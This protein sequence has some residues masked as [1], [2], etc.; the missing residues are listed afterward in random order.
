MDRHA[1][2]YIFSTFFHTKLSTSGFLGVQNWRRPRQLFEKR[3]PLFPKTTGA[4]VQCLQLTEQFVCMTHW[5]KPAEA[6]GLWR[7]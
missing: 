3:L 5:G 7:L 1:D 4:L 2:T 6:L